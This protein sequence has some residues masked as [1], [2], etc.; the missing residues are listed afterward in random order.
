MK[1]ADDLDPMNL[2]SKGNHGAATVVGDAQALAYVVALY[3]SLRKGAQAFAIAHQS[4]CVSNRNARVR[5]VGKVTIELPDLA[6]GLRC[7][8][9]I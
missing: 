5:S 7:K 6:F 1:D 2:H 9:D 3:S 4:F 8:N